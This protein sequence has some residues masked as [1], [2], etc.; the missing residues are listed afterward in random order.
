MLDPVTRWFEVL[1]MKD[2]VVLVPP[3]WLA[4]DDPKGTLCMADR[5][6][7]SM[8]EYSPSVVF[9]TIRYKHMQTKNKNKNK[10][11]N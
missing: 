8:I 3:I 9:K 11:K 4:Q 2:N 1:A 10:N 6:N 7:I 5:V